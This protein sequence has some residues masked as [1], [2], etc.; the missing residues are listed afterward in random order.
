MVTYVRLADTHVEP[1]ARMCAQEGWESYHDVAVAR[2]SLTSPGSIVVVAVEDGVVGFA[3]V[4]SDAA[5][6]AHLSNLLVAP[7]HR[8]R[9]IGRR[10][11]ESA[12]A[13]SGARYLDLV[14]TEGMHAFY[15]SFEHREFPGF[16]LYPRARQDPVT[17]VPRRIVSGGQTGADRAAWDVALERGYEIGGWVPRGRLAEDGAIPVRYGALRE[18]DSA[19]PATRTARNVRESDATLI[20][21]HGE[22]SGGSLLTQEVALRHAKPVL[23]IDL[24]MLSLEEAAARVRG[25]L[26][27]VSPATL[28]VAGPRA[29]RDPAIAAAVAALLR[30]VLPLAR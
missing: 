28:N 23:H 6:H 27:A 4:Q 1:I 8:R 11:V 15:R 7:S 14:S 10:L 21:S 20:V 2:R 30:A 22:L 19:D 24:A 3:H 29:S 5:I 12:F 17:G 9:G 16:R 13:L 18:T 25:W 26:E